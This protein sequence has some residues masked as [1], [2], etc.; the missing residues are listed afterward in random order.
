MFK[1]TYISRKYLFLKLTGVL[2]R[3]QETQARAT[4]ETY[5]ASPEKTSDEELKIEIGMVGKSPFMSGLLSSISG[6]LAIIDENRQIISVNDSFMDMLGIDDPE[7]LLGLRVGDVLECVNAD[8][9]PAGCG[10]TPMCSTCGAAIAMVSSLK[11]DQPTERLCALTTK[12][13]GKEVDIALSVKSQ[14]VRVNQKTFLLLFLQDVTLQHNRAALERTFYHDINNIL[15]GLVPAC[16]LLKMKLKDNELVNIIDTSIHRLEK[17]ISIQRYLVSHSADA[18]KAI[19]ETISTSEVTLELRSF[20]SNH[21]SISGKQLIVDEKNQYIEFKSDISLLLRVLQNMIIN[22]LE[23]SEKGD[24]VKLDI[25][26]FGGELHFKVW[27]PGFIPENVKKRIFQRN[28]STKS[29]E[30]R[31]IGT[32][33]MKLL[34]E[35]LL[36]GSVCFTSS[37]NEGTFFTFSL[38]VHLKAQEAPN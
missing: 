2:F 13:G 16:E 14:P 9:D 38:P 19:F 4:M 20:F 33:S 3:Q 34:G 5:F 36:G 23:A 18:Y 10:T 28:F 1:V 12:K 35:K 22:A 37:Q 32:F 25:E 15:A 29:E 8:S 30:G 21:S 11:T 6:L 27:N 26:T 24:T 17:E 7:V 31:G